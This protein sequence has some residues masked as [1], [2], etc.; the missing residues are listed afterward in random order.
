VATSVFSD[1]EGPIRQD[2][3]GEEVTLR[4]RNAILSGRLKDGDRIVERDVSAELGVSRGPIRDALRQL[5]HEGLVTLLPRRGAR[6]ASLT[7]EEAI[8]TLAIRGALEPLAVET[9]LNRNDPSALAPLEDC[10]A[11]LRAA[12]KTGD[13][14]ALVS[15]DME[16]HETVFRQAGRRFARVWDVLRVP[17]LQTFRIHREFYDSGTTVYRRHRELLD[18]IK[19]GDLARAKA[20]VAEHVIDLRPQLLERLSDSR[21]D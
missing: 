1:G 16:F 17:L 15:L 19:S 5:E 7:A 10:V 4:L 2:S 3:L 9:L 11:R 21:G 18:E 8:E 20:A 13:W 6:V 14:P 12:S